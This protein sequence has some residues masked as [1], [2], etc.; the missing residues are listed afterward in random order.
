MDDQ[1]D[2]QRDDPSMPAGPAPGVVDSVPPGFQHL[3]WRPSWRDRLEGALGSV[4]PGQLAGGAAAAVAGLV[5]VAG[6]LLRGP[7][8][9]PP[10]LALPVAGSQGD[11]AAST[12]SSTTIAPP[13]AEVVVHAAGAVARPGVYRLAGGARVSDLLDA[14]GGP[15]SVADLDRL[16]LAAPL[17][18]GERVFVPLPDQQVPPVGPSHSGT[19]AAPTTDADEPVDLNAATMDELDE[20]P[21]VGPSTAQA[22]LDERDRRG[23]F[24]TVDELLE[25]RGIGDA[26]LAAL[27]DLVRV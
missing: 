18:D 13:A 8:P 21:G 22:I 17:V 26:K 2:D 24:T 9:A 25:V 15:A 12:T 3:G 10:E 11:P 1:R 6:V 16:N 27:R 7:A 20:L 5:V 4:S 19:G 23:S 14:A